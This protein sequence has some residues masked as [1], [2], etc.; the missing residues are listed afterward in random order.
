MSY[1]RGL[2]FQ[3][4]VFSEMGKIYTNCAI[5][6]ENRIWFVTY[7]YNSLQIF[8]TE[9]RLLEEIG[10]IPIGSRYDTDVVDQMVYDNGK[11]IF[12]PKRKGK[13]IFYDFEEKAFVNNGLEIEDS[14]V[15]KK[16]H[17]L[18]G[19]KFGY[20]Y[21][22]YNFP[23]N[24]TEEIVCISDMLNSYGVDHKTLIKSIVF[25]EYICVLPR[26][27]K[28]S[29]KYIL[30]NTN[31]DTAEWVTIPEIKKCW[32]IESYNDGLIAVSFDE[33]YCVKFKPHDDKYDKYN[34]SNSGWS[35]L[36]CSMDRVYINYIHAKSL[37]YIDES[38][39]HEEE[40]FS[41]YRSTDNK[42]FA[43][44]DDV[45]L[46]PPYTNMEF[47]SY[48]CGILPVAFSKRDVIYDMKLYGKG[49]YNEISNIYSLKDYIDE[50]SNKT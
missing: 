12:I 32:E 41:K 13:L 5:R 15:C 20:K 50:I 26:Y 3:P 36:L 45:F 6:V 35:Q 14:I 7:V 22:K 40:S 25:N 43:T 30:Y 33:S 29:N 38:G 19:L 39:I 34:T 31:T 24:K 10:E 4:P 18:Y 21:Y 11:I 46:L 42:M 28:M 48:R 8:D 47:Y 2:K 49:I 23:N 37:Y 27:P 16:E 9:S 1:G 17:I 44:P